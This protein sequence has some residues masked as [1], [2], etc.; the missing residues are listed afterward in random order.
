MVANSDAFGRIGSC[1]MVYLDY[2]ATTPLDP[3]VLEGMAPVLTDVFGNPASLQHIHGREAAELVEGARDRVSHAVGARRQEVIFTSGATEAAALGIIGAVLGRAHGRPNVVV[4][5]TEHKAVLAAAELA[6]RLCQGVVRTVPVDSCGRLDFEFLDAA[7]DDSVAVVAIM[8]AN[9][10][11]GV[12]TDPVE[13]AE[14]IRASGAWFF[15]DSTQ[16]FGKAALDLTDSGID[17]LAVSSHKIYGPKGTGALVATR[18]VRKALVP[19]A[20][21]G[22]Q[23]GGLRGGTVDV[24]A[25]HGFGLAAELAAKEQAADAVRAGG[26]VDRL[27]SGLRSSVSPVLVNS[28]G[29][30]RLANTVNLRF[31]GADADAVMARSPGLAVSTGSACQASVPAPS[32]VLSAMGLD[33]RGAEESLRVSLGRFSTEADIGRAVA[34]LSLAVS[35]VRRTAGW[36]GTDGA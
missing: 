1:I 8:A 21:G 10:E 12:L 23:E 25:V 9:N 18:Q 33:R 11:T 26:L 29:A 36:E 6:A 27:L 16:S 34:E 4:A 13:V 2:N 28:G 19:L 22:G 30:P 24:P 5:A 15:C 35:D 32:H 14:R 17:M 31:P 3:R 20:A 7:V